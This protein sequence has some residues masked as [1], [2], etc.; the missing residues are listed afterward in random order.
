[1]TKA[2]TDI[3]LVYRCFGYISFTN[4]Q[5]TR[6]MVIGLEFDNTREKIESIRLCDLYKKD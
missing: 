5:R 1:M 4:I 2:K 3:E 6:K